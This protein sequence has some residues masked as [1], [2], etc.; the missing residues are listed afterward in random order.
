MNRFLKWSGLLAFGALL[1]LL[2]APTGGFPTIVSLFGIRLN[3]NSLTAPTS[4]IRADQQI[5]YSILGPNGTGKS[6]PGIVCRWDGATANRFCQLGT[7]DNSNVF[8]SQF[9]FGDTSLAANTFIDSASV[10]WSFQ[11]ATSN[12]SVNGSDAT[13]LFHKVGKIVAATVTNPG[14]CT[15]PSGPSQTTTN[16]TLPAL[17][18]PTGTRNAVTFCSAGGTIQ[19]CTVTISPTGSFTLSNLPGSNVTTYILSNTGSFA[20]TLD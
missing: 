15:I 5:Q 17:F 19:A 18:R 16:A 8:T 9:Q 10:T 3:P 7:Y 6:G 1:P 13:L 20:Y 12:C 14:S 4:L 11:T 2:M